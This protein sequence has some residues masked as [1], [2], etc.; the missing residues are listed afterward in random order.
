MARLFRAVAVAL[1]LAALPAVAGAQ[2]GDWG[3]FEDAGDFFDWAFPT[4]D[5]ADFA[6]DVDEDFEPDE[7]LALNLGRKSG[8]VL[9]Q[10][11]FRIR[12]GHALSAL[13]LKLYRLR[14]P[15]GM[16]G[17]QALAE[18]RKA[19]PAGYYD[20]NNI[21]RLAGA[22]AAATAPACEGVR[23][24][25]QAMIGW[26]AS[27]CAAR[28]RL[29]MLDTAVNVHHA[30]LAGRKVVTQRLARAPA[31]GADHGTAVA[32]L[33]VGAADSAFPGLLPEAEL[34]A[35]DVFSVDSRGRVYTDAAELAKGLDW[36]AAQQP[37]AINISITGP[38]GGVLHTAIRRV[39]Q[40]GIGVVAAAGNLGPQSPPQY[41]AAYGEVIAVTAVDR[42]SQVYVKANQGP[43]VALAAPGVDIWTA[44][45]DG[46][47]VFREGTSFAAPYATA[48]LAVLKSREPTLAPAAMLGH[49]RRLARDL[50]PPGAD[51][52]YGAGLLQTQACGI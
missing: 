52:I 4:D 45:A 6:S 10:L 14:P 30:A 44:G 51:S 37:A 24:Y 16:T 29:G 17:R 35:A 9:R 11:G 1:A 46:S 48:A 21:Y 22:T 40:L 36:L 32:A 39:T 7:V 26:S 43:Y 50:G 8:A 38:D 41:P 28:V 47:G 12:A 25:A 15:R 5:P 19:D 20:L 33:L 18:L 2:D 49:L 13:N 34:F 23:C 31:A 27:G 3:G 42:K